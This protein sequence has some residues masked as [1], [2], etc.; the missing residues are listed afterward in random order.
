MVLSRL[1]LNTRHK[2]TQS[3]LARPYEL[4]RTILSGFRAGLQ[5]GERVLYRPEP[6][7]RYALVT[8]IVQSQT[9]PD[10][11]HLE[12]VPHYLLHAPESKPVEL[13]LSAGQV[14]AFRLRANPTVKKKSHEDS[15]PVGPN[16]IRLGLIKEEDQLA[17]LNRKAA[18]SGFEVLRVQ[19]KPD[20]L[21][22]GRKIDRGAGPEVRRTMTHLAVQ[23]DGLLQVTHP[24]KLTATVLAGIGTAKSFGFGLLS[25]APPSL[26]ADR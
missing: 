13:A 6:D 7:D 20:G 15:R 12:D 23:F 21:Q 17:W 25:L 5:E 22:V 9:M 4:H 18:A 16:G 1:M 11:R 26:L 14:L 10:W 3:E 24:E 19:I 8:V 2:R